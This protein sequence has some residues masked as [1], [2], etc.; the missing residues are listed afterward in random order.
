MKKTQSKSIKA[1][2]EHNDRLGRLIKLGN[3]VAYPSHNSLQF[4]RV[5]KINPKMIKVQRIP[6]T[7]WSGESLKYSVDLLV[8]EDSDMTWYLL[9]H[10]S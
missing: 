4:G 7:R 10:C 9:N 3:Y 2:A 6:V 1:E 8:V 5:I